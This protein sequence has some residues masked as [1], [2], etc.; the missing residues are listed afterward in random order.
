MK[1][2]RLLL[3]IFPIAANVAQAQAPSVTIT[4]SGTMTVCAGTT[5][6]LT[7]NVSNAFAGTTSYAVSDIPFTP[8]SVLAGTSLTMPDDT[9]LGPFPIGFQFCFFGNTYTQFYVGSNGW[10]GFSPGQTRAFTANSIPNTTTFVPRNCIMGPWMDFN[11][12]IAGGP[13]IKYQTQGIAPYRRLIVQWTNCPLYQC[14]A[15]KATFQIVL[16]ESTNVIENY[17]TNKP[18][19]ALWAGGKATQGLHNQPG[20]VAFTV[21]GRNSAVWN[22][23]NDGKRFQPN[24][25]ASYTV[26]WTSNGIPIGSGATVSTI[27]NGPGLT[28]IIGKANFPC[29]N[30]IVSD[31][32]DVSI[33][34]SANA[35]FSVPS[36]VCAGQTANFTYTGGST[37]T[38][39]W[40]FS[41]GTPATANGTGTVST[42]WNSPGTYNVGLTVTPSSG[43][44]APGSI[45]QSVTVVAPPTSSFSLPASVC[46]GANANLS[47]TGSAPSGST[48]TWNFGANASPASATGL[49]PHSVSWSSTGSKTV[50]LT[51][52]NG[53]C[54]STTTNTININ[55]APTSTFSNSLSSVCV[56]SNSTFT[57]TGTALPSATYSWDFGAGASVASSNSVGPHSVSWSTSGSKNVTLIVTQGGCS[58]ATT[59]QVITVNAAPTASFSI[60]ASVCVGASATLVYTGSA[61]AAP[62]ASYTWSVD[63]SSSVPGN[64][65]GPFNLSWATS[66]TK[67]IS[68]TVTEAGCSSTTSQ[69]INVIDLPAVTI[70]STN[71]SV[72][73]GQSTTFTASAQAV[74]TS[75]LWS[76]SAG[77]SILSSSSA[78][79]VSVSWTGVSSGTASLIVTNAGC[80]STAASSS[81][82]VI[83]A[84]TAVISAP[85]SGCVGVPISISA[86]GVFAAG[87]TFNWNFDGAQVLSGSNAGPYSL[88]WANGGSKNISLT[89]TSGSCSSSSS[90][91]VAINAAGVYDFTS[92]VSV[93]EGQ[94]SLISLI[95]TPSA[96]ATYNWDFGMG[97]NPSSAT[98]A[99]PHNVSWGISGSA[100]ISLTV[101]ENGCSS[102]T[103]VKNVQV[104][105][106]PTA[107]F[108]VSPNACMNEYVGVIYT[109]NAGAGASFA[110]AYSGG[111]LI[112]GSGTGP[113]ALNYS[114]SGNVNIELQV[115]ENG[116]TSALMSQTVTIH[117]IPSFSIQSP[118]NTIENLAT[119]ISF[120]GSQL[121]GS[122]CDW[123]FEGA[124]IISGSGFGPYQVSW[125]AA[126]TYTIS[127]TYNLN[128][129]SV[130][131]T[132]LVQ[133]ITPLQSTFSAD[134]PVCENA[135]S[136]IVYTGFTL[137]SATFAWDFDGGTIVSGSGSGPFQISWNNP[138]IKNITLEVTQ[139]GITN[140]LITQQ[141][142]VYQIPT[143]IFV[144]TGSLCLGSDVTLNYTGTASSLATY[145]WNFGSGTL[146]NS[147]TGIS[148]S[149]SFPSSSETISLSVT[150]N[151]CASSIESLEVDLQ[152]QPLSL[153]TSTSVV[154]EGASVFVNYTGGSSANFAFNWD[155]DGGNIVSGSAA[156]PI[157]IIYQTAGTKNISLQVDNGGCLSTTSLQTVIVNQTP[158]T[159][160]NSVNSGCSSD[161]VVVT[162]TGNASANA[163]YVWD[164]E[165]AVGYVGDG[166]GPYSALFPGSGSYPIG[167]FVMENGCMSD[168]VEMQVVLNAS[169]IASFTLED[170]VF[171]NQLNTVNFTGQSPLGT[172]MN[173]TYPNADLI[174]GA[175]AGPFDLSWTLPGTYQV[176]LSMDNAG[177]IDGPEMHNVVVLPLPTSDFT[178]SEDTICVG[179]SFTVTYS[180]VASSQ[181]N[182]IWNF[183][184]A[185]VLSGS[186]AGPYQLTWNSEGVH[187]L[188]LIVEVDGVSSAISE[189][190]ISV[191]DIPSALFSLPDHACVGSDVLA[192]Y[193]SIT[194]LN[195]QFQWVV[196]G[197][198]M[199]DADPSNVLLTWNQPGIKNVVLNV[200]D[201]M[202]I[203]SPVAQTIT[204]HAIPQASISLPDYSCKNATIEVNYD[205]VQNSGATYTWSFGSA[206]IISGSN[207]G[208]YSLKYNSSG[209]QHITL[210]V[211]AF[212]CSSTIAD[213][214]IITRDLPIANAGV[215][216]LMCSGE[217][218]Q[219]STPFQA[220]YSYNWFPLAGISNNTISNP[221]FSLVPVHNYIESF[222]YTVT[223]QDGYCLN[224]DLVTLSIAPKP[225]AEFVFSGNPCSY[226]NSFDF[227]PV[228][229][230]DPSA[231]FNWNLGTHAF[232]HLPTDHI[233][234]GISFDTLGQH[235][236]SLQVTEN[237]CVS[238]LFSDTIT[239]YPN[240][241]ARFTASN[242]KGCMPLTSLFEVDSSNDENIHYVW[243][244]G[245]G[246]TAL[247]DSLSHTYLQSGYMSVTLIATNEHGCSSTFTEQDAVQVFEKPIAEFKT[248]PEIVFIGSDDLTLTNLSENALHSYYIIG[249]DTIL[250]A[251]TTYS[252]SDE[253]VYPITQV[254]TSGLGCS[255]EIT[256]TVIVEFGS[257][258]YVPSAFT[259]NNDGKNDEF[260]IIGSEVKEFSLVIFDRWGNEIF[261]SDDINT[262]WDGIASKDNPMPEG[263]YV[264]R[265]EMRSKT[266][267]DIVKSGAITL[268]R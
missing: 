234:R 164:F 86:P 60:P 138:G 131:E 57:Y 170:T 243:S 33:G 202:C 253:G 214:S 22:V 56:G 267:R 208:P 45:S 11:P 189:Q 32:L 47:Y 250:G 255:D 172:S 256:H 5:V 105:A 58:S 241:V 188:S 209:L 168:V 239:V 18:S 35:N 212:G 262:S 51:V 41:S 90:I 64:V 224:F 152:P 38:G 134:S 49:G 87:T 180:G 111:T 15:S 150:E 242:I 198:S 54:S 88:Q 94:S 193:I 112:S 141:V 184:G 115:T 201:A 179:S 238:D 12:G 196:D 145:N 158:T 102:N 107:N 211:S 46:L 19:C 153:F 128:G 69:T 132:S 236:I 37:G 135:I 146:Q 215:D 206:E 263:V 144:T 194:T 114:N 220:G 154:C 176:S 104:N 48:Y 205:G 30:L 84:P 230:F 228:N 254:V 108:S 140:P 175:A 40:T 231:S 245:D 24:G 235:I 181:A 120:S 66:G 3:L 169:P 162:Y 257:E 29:S 142:I 63:G 74:G 21:P 14:I 25:A 213:S 159:N 36:V 123:D 191:I 116:C 113:L 2:F 1:W 43:L 223:V 171:V 101:F 89:V 118:V 185:T 106:I 6:N 173:W 227:T 71:S 109:G 160:F 200:A 52:A 110:W 124:T 183:D 75:Y 9:V 143:A 125:P 65:Q 55:V 222:D 67:T 186:G 93:C 119:S 246:S 165:S 177:C 17:I 233:Q 103:V 78:A 31:T 16:F 195:A 163:T 174:S 50:S 259:P 207:A 127:C 139:L 8:F 91:L 266:N 147:T 53:T 68:L 229:S 7:S 79:P 265:L 161:S 77:A 10:V 182:Y 240:P 76:F 27:V 98:T 148:Y 149:V 249:S 217:T 99:G 42:I 156:G 216:T 83:A 258:Y 264:Y 26:N 133:V 81:I 197:A 187:L 155:F 151:G 225:N 268:L 13:Y 82:A 218:I 167:L 72:C 100:S 92:P 44:C 251:T 80:S 221:N 39:A 97:A 157:E 85:V 210:T 248:Y 130:T 23:T 190:Y 126:G 226:E 117:S 247:G 136:T 4:P 95:G 121:V 61:S 62:T 28:R 34:G 261:E 96:G 199:N 192:N 166:Q 204:I 178:L 237:G 129:C 219:L 70:A 20:T 244:F 137:P 232:T 122:S 59:T 252:F 73:D 260:K 203:S